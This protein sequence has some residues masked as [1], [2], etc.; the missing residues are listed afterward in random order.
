MESYYTYIHMT[1]TYQICAV[2]LD[3]S[4]NTHVQLQTNYISI[5]IFVTCLHVCAQKIDG[6]GIA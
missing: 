1:S 2:Q 5:E 4:N 6:V 3:L